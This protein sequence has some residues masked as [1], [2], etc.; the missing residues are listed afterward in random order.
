MARVLS[1][2]KK[3]FQVHREKQK[4]KGIYGPEGAHL[5]RGLFA[6]RKG[7]DG[8]PPGLGSVTFAEAK[9]L[10]TQELIQCLGS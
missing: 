6:I 4:V 8:I 10:E 3:H 7:D 2:N 9:V 1:F 5:R